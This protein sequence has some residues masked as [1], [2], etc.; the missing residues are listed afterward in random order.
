MED[1]KSITKRLL[2]A[3]DSSTPGDGLQAMHH[4]FDAHS[5]TGTYT[6]TDHSI[7]LPSGRAISPAEAAECLLDSKRTVTFLQGIY[8]AILQLKEVFPGSRLNIFYAGCGPYAT[9]LTPFTAIFTPDEVAFYLLDISEVC[10][11]SAKRLYQSLCISDYV[12][13]FI[14]ADAACYQLP[15]DRTIHMVISETMRKALIIEPQVAIML[16]LIPQMQDKTIF[17]PQEISV[18]LKLL[19]KEEEKNNLLV[20]PH[21]PD[22]ISIGELY[23]IG[24]TNCRQHSPVTVQIP[25]QIGEFNSLTLF[26]DVVVFQNR[27]LHVHDSTLNLPLTLTDV[28]NKTGQTIKLWY[29]MS[30]SPRFLFEWMA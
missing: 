11:D 23:T 29:E 4:L 28:E 1:L 15:D 22:A 24:R 3:D 7:T 14:C 18:S 21:Q 26:T 20:G 10:L 16:N 6:L 9:L 19:K 8:N 2:F 25:Q 12:E 5:G 27:Q 30:S 17:I 13:A